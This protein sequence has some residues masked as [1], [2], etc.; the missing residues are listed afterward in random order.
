MGLETATYISDLVSTNPVGASDLASTSDDHLRLIKSA[1][2]TTFPNISGAVTSTH[3]ELSK[4]ATAN[5]TGAAVDEIGYKG[6]P[7]N[8]QSAGSYGVI[9]ADSG[10]HIKTGS[11]FTYTLPANASIPV[12]I[13]AAV[14]FYNGSGGNSTIAITTDTLELAGVG[15]TGSRTLA[16]SGFAV[17]T[18]VTSTKW[19]ISGA[20]L[21]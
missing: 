20:G 21:S 1:V 4:L 10:K 3:T 15:T 14:G 12:P 18:K 5:N 7:Q 2:K 17:A 16:S 19:S 13:G 8:D 6:I 9:L 11:G